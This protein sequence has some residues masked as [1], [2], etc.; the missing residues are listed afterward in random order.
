MIY[1]HQ[2]YLAYNLERKHTI[3]S[4]IVKLIYGNHSMGKPFS[5]GC[6]LPYTV[7]V[8]T[9]VLSSTVIFFKERRKTSLEHYSLR[10]FSRTHPIQLET[11]YTHFS[12]CKYDGIQRESQPLPR[13][14]I[15]HL[16]LHHSYQHTLHLISLLH[17]IIIRRSI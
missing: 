17:L 12:R 6:L 4:K 10:N 15:W 16:T 8:R 7:R 5:T 9:Y 14:I 13:L 11:T 1:H 3:E 2:S